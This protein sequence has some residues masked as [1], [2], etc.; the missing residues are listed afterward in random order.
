M[1]RYTPY[2]QEVPG[3]YVYS[4]ITV[5]ND[6]YR[7]DKRTYRYYNSLESFLKYSSERDFDRYGYS[8]YERKCFTLY[9]HWSF[10]DLCKVPD[11]HNPDH[12][13][14]YTE[15]VCD[16][17]GLILTPDFLVGEFRK[18]Q[19]SQ[20]PRRYYGWNS[21]WWKCHHRHPRTTNERKQ[22][23]ACMV[24]DDAPNVRGKR[25]PSNLPNTWD[26]IPKHNDKC[27]KTQS[28]RKHQW[29]DNK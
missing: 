16:E 18:Y 29:K 27:W 9:K 3:I 11:C 12:F 23:D 2:F 22:Y 8:I 28:K 13:R 15:V 20:K 25:R 7:T 14:L 5:H 17:N 24:D 1:K 19:A 6:P 26:D 21:G 4:L 10:F